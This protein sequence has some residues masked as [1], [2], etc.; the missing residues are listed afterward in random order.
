MPFL[1]QWLGYLGSMCTSPQAVG[2]TAVGPVAPLDGSWS[3]SDTELALQATF[4]T[5]PL[6]DKGVSPYHAFLVFEIPYELVMELIN[7]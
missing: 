5:S 4:G 7:L 2:D 6:L 1:W 3:V